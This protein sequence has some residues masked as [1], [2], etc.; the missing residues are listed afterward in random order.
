MMFYKNK[1]AIVRSPDGHI[2]FFDNSTG[3]LLGDILA[4]YMF[5]LY[6]DYLLWTSIDQIKENSFTLKV[7]EGANIP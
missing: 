6:R 1:K 3:V 4:I 7:P 2:D 5:I